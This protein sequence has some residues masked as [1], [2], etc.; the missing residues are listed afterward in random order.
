MYEY[1][2]SHC[3]HEFEETQSIKASPLLTCP[4]CNTDHLY[5]VIS[6]GGGMI[7]K[8]SGFYQTDYKSGSS[9][10]KD[11]SSGQKSDSSKTETP[12]VEKKPESK[13]PG[14][15]SKPSSESKTD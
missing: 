7:F 14:T 10:K 3:S 15:T 11:E 9:A 4:Q 2:C 6:I 12:S 13:S 5:R 1:R 8:G